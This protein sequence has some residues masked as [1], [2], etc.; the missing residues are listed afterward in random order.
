MEN[1]YDIS[2]DLRTD[3]LSLLSYTGRV[4]ELEKGG[5]PAHEF[6]VDAVRNKN[7]LKTGS[8]YIWSTNP[9]H[10]NLTLMPTIKMDIY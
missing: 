8:S 6:L 3:N 2:T 9:L 10:Q 1:F 5:Q 4:I 7:L